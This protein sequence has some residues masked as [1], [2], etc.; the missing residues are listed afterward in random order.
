MDT[1]YLILS[2]NA[3]F[4][5]IAKDGDSVA[6]ELQSSDMSTKGNAARTVHY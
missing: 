2:S 5:V 4:A 1:V 6:P 3:P